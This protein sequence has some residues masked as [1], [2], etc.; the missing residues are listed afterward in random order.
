MTKREIIYTV[1]EK[2]NI[3]SDDTD[4]SAELVSSLIDTK[5][6]ILMEQ[7]FSRKPWNIPIHAKQELCL[8][9]ELV[10]KVS[11]YACAG[12]I[13]ATSV[14]L[15]PSIMIKGK[16][17]PLIVRMSDGCAIAL[18]IISMERVPFLFSNKFTQHLI[19]CAVDFDGKLYLF[20][21]D[22]KIK[23]L[24]SIRVTD[25]Y[26]K[27]EL[28]YELRCTNNDSALDFNAVTTD[29]WDTNY[30]VENSM[31]DV[32][33]ELLVKDLTRSLGIPGDKINDADDDRG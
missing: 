15:P 23:F 5:R 25:I 17:G 19:Y 20:S 14:A 26:E 30:P 8:D 4:I 18:N 10:N 12:K 33:I 7:R 2:L 32:I 11:G 22:N 1:F 21:A 24:K 28:A 31:A 6:S 16:E 29:F 9:M 3:M 13:L 27:P